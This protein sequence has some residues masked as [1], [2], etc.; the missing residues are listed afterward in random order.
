MPNRPHSLRVGL[1][2]PHIFAHR[3]ILPHVIFSPGDLG[4]ELADKLSDLGVEVYLY[5]PGPVNTKSKN[6]TANLDGFETELRSRGD[7]YID[8]LRKHPFTFISLARQVQA[9]LIASAYQAAND[10]KLDLIHIYTNEEDLAL[11]F[12]R[13]AKKPIVFT[14]HDPFSFL[15]KYRAV[16]PKY[17][18]LNWLSISLAQRSEMPIGTNWA[19]NIYHGLSRNKFK[20]IKNPTA[21]YVAY[22]GRIIKPK[23]V[24]LAIKA[25]KKYNQLP[26]T[27]KP[28]VLKIAG[29]HYSDN[30]SDDYWNRMIAPELD[31]QIKYVGFI[32]ETSKKNQFLGNAQALLVPSIYNEPFGM[33]TIEALAS[34]T[35]VIGFNMGATKEIIKPR[36]TGLILEYRDDDSAIDELAASLKDIHKIN[37]KFCRDDFEA[38]FTLDQMANQHLAV[39]QKLARQ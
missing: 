33:V 20:P 11:P 39:Y 23:G 4:I 34:G 36:K 12:A 22:F 27:K 37:R 28:L 26:T 25:V 29:K 5:T 15:V 6:I 7:G 30:K 21:D 8:L 14:H 24:H 18:N 9:E 32:K 2:I 3:D 10:G 35:P 1:V 19:G 13:F 38:R 16:F 17:K 31:T